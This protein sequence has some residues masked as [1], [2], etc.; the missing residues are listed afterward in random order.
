[1]TPADHA[2]V[3]EVDSAAFRPPWQI[4]ATVARRAMAQ[5]SWL[6]VAEMDDQI[7]GYQLTTPTPAGAH[8]A[9]LAVRPEWQGRGLGAALVAD[10]IEQCRRQGIRELTVNTQD[11][12]TASLAVYQRLG[13]RRNGV[14]YPVYQLPLKDS[15]KL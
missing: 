11:T 3:V 4:S 5:A 7:V 1:V 6:T 10:M 15:V 14:S 8:L 9:R 13:Y 2:T 12:N